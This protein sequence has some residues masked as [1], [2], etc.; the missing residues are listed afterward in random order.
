MEEGWGLPRLAAAAGYLPTY[1]LVSCSVALHMLPAGETGR[2]EATVSRNEVER[3]VPERRPVPRQQAKN[4]RIWLPIDD[5]GRTSRG[6]CL[7]VRL[8]ITGQVL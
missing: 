5:D 7:P 2:Q 8:V 6:W 1:P 3:S 4:L